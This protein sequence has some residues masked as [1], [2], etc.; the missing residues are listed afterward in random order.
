MRVCARHERRVCVCV[1]VHVVLYST[2][3]RSVHS[4]ST[5]AGI[6]M[7]DFQLLVVLITQLLESLRR[8][9]N[10]RFVMLRYLRRRRQRL[11]K[12]SRDWLNPTYLLIAEKLAS[13][14]VVERRFWALPR[15]QNWFDVL[16]GRRELDFWWKQNFRVNRSTFMRI[17]ELVR[18]YMT[19]QDNNFRRATSVDDCL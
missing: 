4:C 2:Q 1:C 7:D 17:V 9:R 11:L 18:P 13:R 16:L 15:P 5:C 6:N 3:I 10:G 19:T 12:L 14:E 8:Q